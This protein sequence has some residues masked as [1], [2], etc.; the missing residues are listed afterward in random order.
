MEEQWQQQ[1]LAQKQGA[2]VNTTGYNNTSCWRTMQEIVLQQ[3]LATLVLELMLIP[4]IAN[5]EKQIV[6]GYDFS[7]NGDNKISMG[8]S[9]WL[10]LE[11]IYSKRYLESGFG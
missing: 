5:A 7:G 9:C 10:C 1:L 3:G 8:S 4:S 2:A 11:L 6:I